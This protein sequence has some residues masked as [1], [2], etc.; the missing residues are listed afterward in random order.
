MRRNE[1]GKMIKKKLFIPALL[2]S[3]LVLTG[4][5]SEKKESS[6]PFPG[7][8]TPK[9][10]EVDDETTEA[11]REFAKKFDE[12]INQSNKLLG[13]FNKALDGL[14]TNDNSTSQ[15]AQIM[16]KNINESRELVATLEGY[17]AVV[18]VAPYKQSLVSYLNQQH[19]LFLDAVD[20][21]NQESVNKD[22]LRRMYLEV[23]TSQ[24]EVESA[25]LTGE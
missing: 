8:G 22:E 15:F 6:L 9:N 3:I 4:C 23:K 1:G 21:A 25:F 12:T 7:A 18:I 11:I 2:S 10:N 13:T 14:Y 5:S 24:A 20:M 19:Q 17:E 16:K